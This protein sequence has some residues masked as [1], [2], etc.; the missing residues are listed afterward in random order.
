MIQPTTRFGQMQPQLHSIM[1]SEAAVN[2]RVYGSATSLNAT[3]CN[4]TTS[5][6]CI[7][8]LYDLG[9]FRR[10]PHV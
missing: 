5:P 4:S 3:Y 7:W 9:N 8:A 6:D 1:N 10:Y 2:R